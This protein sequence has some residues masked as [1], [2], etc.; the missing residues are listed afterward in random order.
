MFTDQNIILRRVEESVMHDPAQCPNECGRF[1]KGQ[2]RKVNLRRHVLFECGVLPRFSCFACKK[3]FC[4]RY[5]LKLHLANV[6]KIL[7]TLAVKYH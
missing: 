1:Y 5:Q 3:R 4:R 6:H 7:D 2:H